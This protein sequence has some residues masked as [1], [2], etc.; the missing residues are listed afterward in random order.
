MAFDRVFLVPLLHPL[1][2]FVRSSFGEFAQDGIFVVVSWLGL[3][4]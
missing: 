4:E 1:V 2:D 3:L